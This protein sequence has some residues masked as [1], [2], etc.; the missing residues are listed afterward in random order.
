MCRHGYI[1]EGH[2]CIDERVHLRFD[3]GEQIVGEQI[4][5]PPET[6]RS[7]P[8]ETDKNRQKPTATDSNRQKLTETDKNRQ[9]PA[10]TDRICKI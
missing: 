2:G 1:E 5:R 4:V 9:K 7:R 8:T 6:D 3:F 10:E